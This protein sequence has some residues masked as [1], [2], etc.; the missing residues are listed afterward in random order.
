M[1]EEKCAHSLLWDKKA[2]K[3][4][5]V[6]IF[7]F[8]AMK[9]ASCAIELPKVAME[10]GCTKRQNA[11]KTGCYRDLLSGNHGSRKF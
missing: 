4:D 10:N 11:A 7:K 2:E 8:A 9:K 5:A 3:M 1:E 6:V